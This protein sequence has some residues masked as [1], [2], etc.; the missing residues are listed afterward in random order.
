MDSVVRCVFSAVI[1][2]NTKLKPM[3]RAT[4][5]TPRASPR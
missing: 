4:N 2:T 5:M 1:A 3:N